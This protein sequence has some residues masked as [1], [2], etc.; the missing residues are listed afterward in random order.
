MDFSRRPEVLMLSAPSCWHVKAI[1]SAYIC[2]HSDISG[3]IYF[4]FR[5][6]GEKSLVATTDWSLLV[7]MHYRYIHC[8]KKNKTLDFYAPQLVPAGTA[9]ARISYGNS[10]RKDFR[11][12]GYHCPF[13]AKFWNKIRFHKRVVF[14]GVTECEK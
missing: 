1:V 5:R 4:R 14:F 8:L 12:V 13:T 11:I 2:H 3:P 6:K 7:T 9:E 10:V